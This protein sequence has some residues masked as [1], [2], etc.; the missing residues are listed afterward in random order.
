MHSWDLANL[1]GAVLPLLHPVKE[2]NL[3]NLPGTLCQLNKEEEQ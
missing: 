1:R 2:P 3:V